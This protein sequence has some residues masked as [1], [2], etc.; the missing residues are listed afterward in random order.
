[1]Q[2]DIHTIFK[3]DYY[4]ITDFKCRCTDCLTSQPEYCD[5]F[6]ISFI[7]RG[8]FLFNVFRRSLDSYNGCALITKPGYEHTVTHTHTVPDECTI[9]E[10]DLDFYKELSELYN[11]SA[12][13]RDRD[14][15]C[16][17]VK[18]SAEIEFLHFNILQKALMRSGSRL[19]IDQ[20]VFP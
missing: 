14:I 18:T 6:C 2:A 5:T 11:L 17:L 3:S 12:F 19:E 16:T 13:F 7:R 20:L 1:M 8:N 9:F 4:R 10:F 15:D